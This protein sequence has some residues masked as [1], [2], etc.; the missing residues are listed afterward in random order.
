MT[1]QIYDGGCLC[2]AVRYRA[3]GAPLLVEYCHC[4]MCRRA[5]GAPVVAWADFP[6]ERFRILQGAPAR[7]ASSQG[8]WRSFCGACGSQLTFQRG[9]S[10]PKIT[11]TVASLD[12]PQ[13]LAPRHHI[14]AADALPWLELA[15]ALPRHPQQLPPEE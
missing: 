2:G 14:F 1:E 3:E 5:A 12:E 15:D 10:P 4:S 8:V 7:Y 6:R 13:A 9:E 11:L